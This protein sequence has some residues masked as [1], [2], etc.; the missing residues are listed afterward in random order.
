MNV[1]F[2]TRI[3][4]L[5]CY[6]VGISLPVNADQFISSH[7]TVSL[8]SDKSTIVPGESFNLA[9]HFDLEPGWH[10]YWKNPGDSGRAPKIEF[11]P[12]QGIVYP[13]DF[14][15]PAPKRIPYNKNL[16]N[17]GYDGS[18]WLPLEASIEKSFDKKLLTVSS[19]INWLVC[20]EDCVPGK[21][22]L[23]LELS[24]GQFARASKDSDEIQ[25]ALKKTPQMSSDVAAEVI[26]QSASVSVVV[27]GK[28]ALP[29]SMTFFPLTAGVIEYS[30]PQSVLVESENVVSIS[31]VKKPTAVIDS[32]SFSGVLFSEEGFNDVGGALALAVNAK[33]AQSPSEAVSSYS[34]G[35]V[36]VVL[37]SAFLGGL[38]LNL[39]PCVF[40]VLSFK[41]LSFLQSG[42]EHRE[43]VVY[44]A[45]LYTFGVVLSFALLGLGVIVAKQTGTTLGWGFQLQNS[46]FVLFSI[47]LLELIALNFFGVYDLGFGVQCSAGKV[48]CRETAMGT[49]LSGV[50]ATLLASPCTAPF[51]GSAIAAALGLPLLLGVLVFIVLG[52]GMASPFLLFALVPSLGK[53]LPRPGAWME[54]LRNLL[55]FPIVGACVWLL[56]VFGAQQ[57]NDAQGKVL[58][59]LVA[60]ALIVWMYGRS[61]VNHKKLLH[62][63][64]MMV[65]AII[66]I[67]GLYFWSIPTVN[68]I[69]RV[70][71]RPEFDAY[72]YEWLPYSK[73]TIAELR[74]QGRTVY[75]DFTAAWCITC[76]VNKRVVFSSN[77]VK[78]IIV[79]KNVAL[80]R[81]DWT[82]ADPEITEALS[83]Y[84]RDGVPLNL[85]F[86]KEDYGN[87]IIL[88]AILTPSIVVAA[89]K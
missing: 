30:A 51:M 87:P 28:S 19:S 38:I 69:E 84:G 25:Q 43:K 15:W 56:W 70:L 64:L 44:N 54:T 12:V 61:K 71:K 59:S 18:V 77:V 52:L 49:F 80:V 60:I 32:D 26:D 2:F 42:S 39:M 36:A 27:K 5:F 85:I 83:S 79:D 17:F 47:F 23:T 40:P 7:A 46:Y 8:V 22:D 55:G 37:L 73:K 68:K 20:K 6:C 45:L 16:I 78:N 4:A 76:Q 81:G 86:T 67:G 35:H 29:H 10:I 50:L 21:A 11:S 1:K 63:W 65:G 82:N 34:F 9:V 89:L 72:G 62:Q 3:L 74:T 48:K 66:T 31:F 53:L 41:A 24:V 88:P 58:V 75:V 33:T 57:G 14:S 13:K